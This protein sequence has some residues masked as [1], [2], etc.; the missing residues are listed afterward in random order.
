MIVFFLGLLFGIIQMIILSR[1]LSSATSGNVKELALTLI[2][3]LVLY[4]VAIGLL[5]LKFDKYIVYAACGYTAGLPIGAIC[6]FVFI[7]F[8]KRIDFG[9]WFIRKR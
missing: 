3:K 9:R 1:L 2:I 7:T 6:Y 8:F 5:I 4:V